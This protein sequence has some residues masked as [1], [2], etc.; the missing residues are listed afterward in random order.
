[1]SK[2]SKLSI[3]AIV[4]ALAFGFAF[5]ISPVQADGHENFD[6]KVS[7]RINGR[8]LGLSKELPVDVYVNGG[9]AFTFEFGDVIET[10]LP[11]GSYSIAVKL[12]GTDITVMSLDAGEIPAGVSVSIRATLGAE[13]AP[14]LR[15]NVK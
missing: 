14:T 11:S 13:K 10:S 4:I 7:H 2:F 3:F 1:M 5:S 6:L 15:V 9:L 8:S 12:A